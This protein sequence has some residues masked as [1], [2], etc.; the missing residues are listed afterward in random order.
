MVVITTR[1][2]GGELKEYRGTPQGCETAHAEVAA[3]ARDNVYARVE[4][5]TEADLAPAKAKAARAKARRIA[6][7]SARTLL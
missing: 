7:K 3:Y 2:M 1:C 5:A 6:K 4:E